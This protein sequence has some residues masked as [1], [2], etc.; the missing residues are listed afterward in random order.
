MGSPAPAGFS[1]GALVPIEAAACSDGSDPAELEQELAALLTIA[2]EQEQ[3]QEQGQEQGQALARQP[4]K[5]RRIVGQN[6]SAVPT[7][8][9]LSQKL[10][11]GI[12]IGK[13]KTAGKGPSAVNPKVAK[14]QREL[15]RDARSLARVEKM[16]TP[17]NSTTKHR[18]R[19]RDSNWAVL[20]IR[21]ARI[22]LRLYLRSAGGGFANNEI[23]SESAITMALDLCNLAAYQAAQLA[24]SHRLPTAS[25][26]F[27]AIVLAQETWCRCMNGGCW[28]VASTT[29]R[30]RLSFEALEEV[31]ERHKGDKHCVN[32][33]Y[34]DTERAFK[35]RRGTVRTICS[36]NFGSQKQRLSK[37]QCLDT[38]LRRSG[39]QGLH[40]HI[41]EMR[42]PLVVRLP[43]PVLGVLGAARQR[44]LADHRGHVTH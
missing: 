2:P 21:Q 10:V 8:A 35:N 1:G 39:D 24:G 11:G 33:H 9:P 37:I 5:L 26:A 6:A 23:L 18:D 19:E 44:A 12:P 30:N 25:A 42:P 20:R 16:Q 29:A 14:M 28:E 15:N 22:V 40:V 4:K 38:L 17:Q 31:Y 3:E 41:C 34:E 13:Q 27:W 36:H 7:S 43:K 32:E